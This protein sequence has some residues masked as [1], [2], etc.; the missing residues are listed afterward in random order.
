VPHEA[1][2]AL[3]T[4]AFAREMLDLIESESL[5]TR[6]R[7]LTSARLSTDDGLMEGILR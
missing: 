4:Y 1:A 6:V 2:R 7:M 5:R 3:L